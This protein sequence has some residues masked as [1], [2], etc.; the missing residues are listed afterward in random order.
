MAWYWYVTSATDSTKR[1]AG[2]YRSRD[3]CERK[4]VEMTDMR[5]TIN[6][7]AEGHLP[8]YYVPRPFKE[9]EPHEITRAGSPDQLLRKP[10]TSDRE[11]VRATGTSEAYV[12]TASN[13]SDGTS[14]PQIQGTRKR[15]KQRIKLPDNIYR[16]SRGELLELAEALGMNKAQLVALKANK[17]ELVAIMEAYLSSDD[18]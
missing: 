15:S 8:G 10:I 18:E 6:A 7:F 11:P 13:A 5:S 1:L 9:A 12:S 2:P 14:S 4:C 3:E 16:F 17:Q